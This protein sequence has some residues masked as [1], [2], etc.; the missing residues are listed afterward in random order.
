MMLIEWS[1]Q[2]NKHTITK[3]GGQLSNAQISCNGV[4]VAA[5]Q[6]KIHLAYKSAIY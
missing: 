3:N 1:S 4:R 5:K 2:S 6:F